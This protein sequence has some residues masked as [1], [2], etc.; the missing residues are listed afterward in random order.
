MVA[1]FSGPGGEPFALLLGEDVK[2]VSRW[3]EINL[4]RRG[5]EFMGF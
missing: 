4:P 3:G 1:D 5:V 2:R